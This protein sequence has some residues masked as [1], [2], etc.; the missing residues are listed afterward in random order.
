[1]KKTL[2]VFI[3]LALIL[4]LSAISLAG[5]RG[6]IRGSGDLETREYELNNFTTIDVSH[7]FTYEVTQSSF[8][9]VTVTADDNLFK[10]IEVTKTGE[11]LEVG[12][13]PNYGYTNTHLKVVITMPELRSIDVSGAS[14]GF[15]K[16]FSS[17]EVLIANI[18][19][20]SSLDLVDITTGDVD[21]EISG[22]SGVTGSLIANDAKF[23][24]SGASK[25]QLTD[26]AVDLT[27]DASGASRVELG[28]F[29]V[30]D[31]DI[32]FSGA[33]WGTVS[34]SG[35]LDADLSGASRLS[36]IGDPVFG[37][38][39]TSGASSISRK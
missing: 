29:P 39:N 28:S 16:G 24:L 30:T 33:S 3:T 19:G 1:M 37:N 10:Y 14:T 26:S 12:M 22:A 27:V 31:A 6:L 5:C 20:A 8:Y 18:S 15:I 7:S 21:F 36:Y 23:E 2:V 17:S 11:R 38:V 4:S 34:L 9:G 32:V 13:K 35:T 25:I